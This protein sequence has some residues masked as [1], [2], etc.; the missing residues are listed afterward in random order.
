ML[1]ALNRI[2][3]RMTESLRS[4]GADPVPEFILRRADPDAE[5]PPLPDHWA[6]PFIND[7]LQGRH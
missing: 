6:V 1:D 7:I 2:L 4:D 3:D 5:L